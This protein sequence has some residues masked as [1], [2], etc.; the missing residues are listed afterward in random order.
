[1]ITTPNQDA[2]IFSAM[3]AVPDRPRLLRTPVVSSNLVSLGYRANEDDDPTTAMRGCGRLEVEFANGSV[4]RYEDVP[5]ALF[6]GLLE[7]PSIGAYFHRAIKCGGFVFAQLQP[8][9]AKVVATACAETFAEMDALI[10]RECDED[11][12]EESHRR[13]A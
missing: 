10:K 11:A 8:A 9:R 4:Y 1:M 5:A 13:R 3:K 7:A 2:Q 12:V 6:L